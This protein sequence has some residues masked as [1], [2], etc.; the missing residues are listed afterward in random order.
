MN[1]QSQI[2]ENYFMQKGKKLQNMKSAQLN[3]KCF[4]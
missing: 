1:Y 4:Q 2:Y 3:D